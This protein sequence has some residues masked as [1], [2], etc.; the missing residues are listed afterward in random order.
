MQCAMSHSPIYVRWEYAIS[1]PR[2]QIA[3]SELVQ[4]FKYIRTTRKAKKK[5]QF[6]H[7]DVH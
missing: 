1:Q 4:F 5:T 6:A 7:S 2:N 3:S